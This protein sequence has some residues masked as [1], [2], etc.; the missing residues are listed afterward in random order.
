MGFGSVLFGVGGEFEYNGK[1]IFIVL[2]V[3]SFILWLDRFFC[4]NGF[5]AVC[6]L[7]KVNF[8]ISKT[9]NSVRS[10]ISALK[11]NHQLL[12]FTTLCS[13]ISVPHG[14]RV[15]QSNGG[16]KIVFYDFLNE[17]K[18]SKMDSLLHFSI[19]VY[20]STSNS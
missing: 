11:R 15:P 20:C 5:P 4:L 8:R 16:V 6:V 14:I 7:C 10:Q 12:S 9:R 1:G 2:N 19:W 17:C 18:L 3:I 13:L